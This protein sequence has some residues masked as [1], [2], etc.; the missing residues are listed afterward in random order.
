MKKHQ[1]PNAGEIKRAEE[2]AVSRKRQ[3]SYG[4][5]WD[6]VIEKGQE[7]L[8]SGTL[9]INNVNQVLLAARDKSNFE[10]SSRDQSLA[11]MD[12]VYRFS[13]Q[14]IALPN[15]Q[16]RQVYEGEAS[17]GVD[18]EQPSGDTHKEPLG[19]RDFYQS[20]AGDTPPRRSGEVPTG[21]DSPKD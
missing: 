5:I 20:L 8:E 11:L 3:A 14:E 4:D 16:N 10:K 2:A 21:N 12:M 7:A 6:T 1:I 9:Q 15:A 18:A 13:S 17:P 19:P